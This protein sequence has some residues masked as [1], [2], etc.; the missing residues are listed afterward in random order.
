[1]NDQEN[2]RRSQEKVQT[3]RPPSAHQQ[4]AKFNE[5]KEQDKSVLRELES[6]YDKLRMNTDP[7]FKDQL[8]K[9][10]QLQ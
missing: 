2:Y 8:L 9:E 5:I 6:Q 4:S 3:H 10:K 1:M 7:Y